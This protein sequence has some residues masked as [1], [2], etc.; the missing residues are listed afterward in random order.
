MNENTEQKK[1]LTD[2]QLRVVQAI[3][4]VLSAIALVVSIWVSSL[5]AAEDN[6]I[7]RWLFL[8]IFLV[9]VLGRRRV[10]SHY[11]LRLNLFGLALIDGIAAG[12]IFYASL[13]FFSSTDLVSINMDMWLKVLIIGAVSLALLILGIILPLLRYIKRRDEGTL[14]PV[15]IEQKEEPEDN[16]DNDDDVPDDGPMTIEQQIKAMTKE[17]DEKNKDDK[18]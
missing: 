14:Q 18:E 13:L 8:I 16:T 3:A 10:E 11:H 4:G 12:V 7:L 9:V 17:L 5:E 1:K 6:V 2:Y 15:R